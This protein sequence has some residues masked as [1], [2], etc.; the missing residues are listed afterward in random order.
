MKGAARYKVV[1]TQHG[2]KTTTLPLTKK[3]KLSNT[4]TKGK[5][6][7]IKV[8]AIASNKKYSSAWSTKTVM[9]K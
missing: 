7:T 5:K 3:T 1:V 8:Q 4:I 6:Y 9:A 2:V